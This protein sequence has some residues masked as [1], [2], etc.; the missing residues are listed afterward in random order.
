[1]VARLLHLCGLY[2]G[3][4]SEFSA[5]GADNEEG[6]WENVNF[7]RMNDNILVHMD[8]GWDLPPDVSRGWK[9]NPEVISL[10]SEAAGLIERFTGREPWGWKDPRNS[11]T[12]PFWSGLLPNLKVVICVRSPLEVAQSLSARNFSSIAFGLKLWLAYNQRILC[13]VPAEDIVVTHYDAYFYDPRAELRRVLGLLE[14]PASEKHIEQACSTISG[15][16]RHHRAPADASSDIPSEVL[17]CYL[18]LCARA[19][20]VYES[21]QKAVGNDSPWLRDKKDGMMRA[22]EEA[23]QKLETQVGTLQRTVDEQDNRIN[24]LSEALAERDGQI[25]SLSEALTKRAGEIVSLNQAV[26]ELDAQPP[27]RYAKKLTRRGIA[28]LASVLKFGSRT[29]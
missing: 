4:E 25:A 15:S 10:Q 18:D 9:L 23:I 22:R 27:L 7:V 1:M 26:A 11:L 29:P 8:A 6:Y 16:L 20:L 12:M 17:Q 28:K 14:L 24:S 19:G 2:L 3:H 13:T 5:T 21:V